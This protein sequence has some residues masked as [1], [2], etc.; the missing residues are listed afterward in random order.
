MFSDG[1][2]EIN[3]LVWRAIEIEN[4]LAHHSHHLSIKQGSY[5]SW[6]T[7]KVMEFDNLDSRPGKSWNVGP[8]PGKSWN[9]MLA[10]VLTAELPT[11]LDCLTCMRE[12]N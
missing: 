10:N 7:W 5:R 4:Q 11:I 2:E 8:G 6:K 9:V 12:K 3:S 1:N